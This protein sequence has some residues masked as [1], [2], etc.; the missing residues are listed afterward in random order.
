MVTLEVCANGLNSALAAQEGGANRVEL[1]DNLLEGG[2]TPSYGQIMM[3][4]KMLNIELYPIIR[5]RGG[6][7]FYSDLEFEVMKADVI[8]CKSLKCDGVVFGILT[9]DGKVDLHRCK[10][11]ADLAH[12]MPVTF[13]RAF[14]A[15]E[16][17]FQA[18]EDIISLGIQRIL[19]SGGANS[20]FE[21][22]SMLKTLIKQAAGR[23]EIMPGAG[24]NTS[25]ILEIAKNTGAQ[26]IHGT[27]AK[28]EPYKLTHVETVRN[29]HKL[30]STL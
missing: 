21:G 24:I 3:S 4:R 18:L 29:I 28:D 23:I 20:A 7:F 25:N 14:D 11:L 8:T 2:T 27:F 6:D 30:L 12:P 22:R 10:I 15:A 19:S 9:I 16:D 26:S 13:H 5:P 17:M 1:C